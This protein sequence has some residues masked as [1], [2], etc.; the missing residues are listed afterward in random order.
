[1]PVIMC[2][3]ANVSLHHD[4]NSPC[5]ALLGQLSQGSTFHNNSATEYGGALKIAVNAHNLTG[6]SVSIQ[7]SVFTI[8][9]VREGTCNV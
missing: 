8:N 5:V 4:R 9:S 7:G 6:V 2:I 3:S 1:V